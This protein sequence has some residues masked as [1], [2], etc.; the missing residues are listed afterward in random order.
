MKKS[1]S[2]PMTTV[3]LFNKICSLLEENGQM[4]EILDYK[5]ETSKSA[6][7]TTYE[8]EFCNDLHYGGNEGIYLR[9]G[10]VRT[11]NAGNLACDYPLGTFKTLNTSPEAMRTMGILLADFIVTGR[12]YVNDNLDDFTWEGADVYPIRK[13]GRRAGWSY[14]CS[15]MERALERKDELLEKY[16][17]VIVRD[18]ETR[19]EAVYN[20]E[21]KEG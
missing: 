10:L 17:S 18:N 13:D 2:K 9:I 20:K 21:N 14:S 12:K 6:P 8:F 3:E 1:K 15:S 11:L 7:I 4:P 5:Q 16:E 19:E